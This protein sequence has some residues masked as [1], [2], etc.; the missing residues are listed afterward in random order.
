MTR[1]STNMPNTDAQYYLR[2]Q[3]E[4][5]SKI[6]SKIAGQSRILELRD[7]PMAASHAVRYESYLARL[8][9]FEKNTLYTKDHLNEVDSYLRQANDI[10]QRVR[11]L[12]VQGANGTY[13]PEDLKYMAVETNELLKELVSISNAVGS[14]GKQLFAGDKAVTEPF[15][16]VEGTVQGGGE[17]MVTKVEYRGAGAARKTEITDRTYTDL[18]ISGGEA[19]WAERMQIFSTTDATDYRAAAAGAFFVDGEEIAVNQGDTL[20]AIVA[21][22]NES[23]APVKAYVDPETN[24]I[25]L[26]GTS[27]HLIRLEDRQG[28]QVLQDLGLIRQQADPGAPNWNP[29]ARVSGGSAF[30]MV[31]RL[32]DALFRGD[33][34]FVGSQG[35]G[36][37]DLALSNIQS[38]IAQIGSR[39]ERAEMAW[40][41]LNEEIPNV[42]AALSRESGLDM[43]TAATDL[44]MMDFAHKA[45]LQIAAKILPTTLLDYLR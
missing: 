22:I 29:S 14:D 1:V 44:A 38:R 6:Q 28:S 13:A 39:Q 40:N 27:A 9:R 37:M 23:S 5:L 20:H 34:D 42:A 25:A 26:E 16:I 45:S 10:M 19:F 33:Q 32:R 2:R 7:D 3:E 12:S 11:E 8:E 17:T 21:K 35:I 43:A 31:I 15:R 36:G 4:G 24:G 30:D 41:R 18:D